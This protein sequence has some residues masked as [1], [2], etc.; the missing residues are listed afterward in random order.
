MHSAQVP[1]RRLSPF[2]GKRFRLDIRKRFFTRGWSGPAQAAQGSGQ[3]P[4]LLV[5]EEHLDSAL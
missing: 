4:K 2:S 3:S 1:G 5:F